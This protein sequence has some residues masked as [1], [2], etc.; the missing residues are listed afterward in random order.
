MKWLAYTPE[1]GGIGS[2]GPKIT[3]HP[4]LWHGKAFHFTAQSQSQNCSWVVSGIPKWLRRC[5]VLGSLFA[6]QIW[7]LLIFSVFDGQ[8]AWLRSVSTMFVE[9]RTEIISDCCHFHR[10]RRV[11]LIV[12]VIMMRIV[13]EQSSVGSIKKLLCLLQLS[14]KMCQ[15]SDLPDTMS[16]SFGPTVCMFPILA[17]ATIVHWFVCYLFCMVYPNFR[18]ALS[19]SFDI[20]GRRSAAALLKN[21]RRFRFLSCT[22]TQTRAQTLEINKSK[23]PDAN[24]KQFPNEY[25]S[26]FQL[27]LNRLEVVFNLHTWIMDGINSDERISRSITS[28][29]HSIILLAKLSMRDN[30]FFANLSKCYRNTNL[31]VD[32][33]SHR[34]RVARK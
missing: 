7:E 20:F 22:T 21:T 4:G 32:L 33:L 3:K 9:S 31:S 1:S 17:G 34:I 16:A 18:D 11:I 12:L 10:T 26:T 23:S 30:A 14:N 15:V 8:I 13:V 24:W 27:Q 19:V 6:A 2:T 29:S 5:C 28:K 25:F